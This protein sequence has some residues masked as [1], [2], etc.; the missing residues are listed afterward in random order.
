MCEQKCNF[1][2]STKWNVGWKMHRYLEKVFI[3]EKIVCSKTHGPVPI[4][5]WLI[6][7]VHFLTIMPLQ[8]VFMERARWVVRRLRQTFNWA[9]KGVASVR[10][11]IAHCPGWQSALKVVVLQMWH[12]WQKNSDTLSRHDRP[13]T[14]VWDS[15][16][17][18]L[19]LLIAG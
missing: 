9:M 5:E 6:K 7:L 17:A 16:W 4:I 12:R 19:G 3:E 1:A 14:L 2:Y 8:N 11:I 10:F 13:T 18:L 15:Q